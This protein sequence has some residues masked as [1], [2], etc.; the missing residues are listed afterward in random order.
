VRVGAAEVGDARAEQRGAV[1][2]ERGV[3]VGRE[4]ASADGAAPNAPATASR[5]R[6][7]YT[8]KPRT[9]LPCAGTAP[10]AG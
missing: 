9:A 4:R 6:S 5:A 1:E 7:P 8:P 2:R 3:R 10:C